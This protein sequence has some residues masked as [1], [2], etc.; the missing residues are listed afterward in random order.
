MERQAANDCSV[1]WS[2]N[3]LTEEAP[4]EALSG[5]KSCLCDQIETLYKRH[6]MELMTALQA[7]YG[8][9]PPDPD[10]VIQQ[11]FRK[12]LERGDLTQIRNPKAYIW[13]T[14]RN[15]VREAKRSADVR[16]RHDFEVEEIFFDIKG[17]KSTPERIIIVKDQLTVINKALRNM[18]E[19]RRRA[20]ILHR[21]EGLSYAEIGRRLRISRQNAAKHVTKGIADLDIAFMFEGVRSPL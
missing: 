2:E 14:A 16:S 13:R 15:I 21:V 3:V 10:D 7:I 12:L 6:H 18:P 11:T 9:G 1:D 8:A 19:K 5:P 20:V 4:N 17:D